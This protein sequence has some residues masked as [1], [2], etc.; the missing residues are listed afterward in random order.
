VGWRFR[1]RSKEQ[2]LDEE[3]LAHLAIEVKR[4]IEA[5]EIPEDAERAAR[6]QFGNVA[7]VK[8]VTRGEWGF[9]WLGVLAQDAK[10][11]MRAMRKTPGF[12]AVVILTLALGLGESKGRDTRAEYVSSSSGRDGCP[13]LL[14]TAPPAA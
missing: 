9:A 7:L 13:V 8:E 1:R 11:G 10:Y 6:R 12:A 14:I 2:E 3:I 4:R 5:G